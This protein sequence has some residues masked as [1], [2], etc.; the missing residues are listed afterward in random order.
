MWCEKEKGTGK[1]DG[2]KENFAHSCVCVCISQM[3]SKASS[4]R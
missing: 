3:V 2:N 4:M 1:N